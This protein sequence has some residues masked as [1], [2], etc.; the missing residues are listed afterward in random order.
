M[1]KKIIILSRED[2][3]GG[4]F[5]VGAV[6]WLDVPVAQQALRADPA[7]VSAYPFASAAELTAL[8]AGQVAEVS[9]RQSYLS[10]ATNA[11][12]RSDL[13]ARYNAA[14]TALTASA[15]F[16]FFGTS[17]DGTTWTAGGA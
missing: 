4:Y 6:F 12:I 7:A 16:K 14:Q 2:Q 1:A 3:P 11:A 9:V 10:G 17:W 8:R 13:I 15:R 5:E